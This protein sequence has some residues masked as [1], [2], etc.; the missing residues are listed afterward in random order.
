MW[1]AAI[2]VS[3]WLVGVGTWGERLIRDHD[4]LGN[5]LSADGLSAL[6]AGFPARV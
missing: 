5:T 4:G 6:I 3:R 2:D 1:V